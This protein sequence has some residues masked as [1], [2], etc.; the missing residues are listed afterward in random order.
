VKI[1]S[2]RRQR[3]LLQQRSSTENDSSFESKPS[4]GLKK[5]SAVC[6]RRRRIDRLGTDKNKSGSVCRIN[7]VNEVKNLA[8]VAVKNSVCV[9]VRVQ[10][11]DDPCVGSSDTA[12]IADTIGVC[13]REKRIRVSDLKL[14]K[15]RV[16]TGSKEGSG[17]MCRIDASWS[18]SPLEER[19][20]CRINRQ[21]RSVR[22]SD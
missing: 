12:C 10:E 21:V 8:C 13:L 6:R 2:V 17:S 18:V 7:R 20:V 11:E 5:G 16:S 1:D 3:G 19:S 4:R 9:T 15:G 22:V 14:T